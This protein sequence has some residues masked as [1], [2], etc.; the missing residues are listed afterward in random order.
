MRKASV[1]PLVL[2][3]LFVALAVSLVTFF[4]SLTE[5]LIETRSSCENVVLEIKTICHNGAIIR[6]DLENK[7]PKLDGIKLVV[8]GAEELEF[9]LPQSDLNQGSVFSSAIPI[10]TRV[11]RI[12]IIPIAS[13]KECLSNPYIF[14]EVR[15]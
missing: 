5:K 9:N 6:L 10:T 4:V 14:N 13:G 11:D 8:W 15:C 12:A 7:G 3:I 2:F 1:S